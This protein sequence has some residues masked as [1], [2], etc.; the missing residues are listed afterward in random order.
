MVWAKATVLSRFSGG[1]RSSQQISLMPPSVPSAVLGMPVTCR[2]GKNGLLNKQ[3]VRHY[4]WQVRLAEQAGGSP[5]LQGAVHNDARAE[6]S[7]RR[8]PEYPT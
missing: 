1:S 5:L 8:G 6:L 3:R 7:T 2:H 4:Y